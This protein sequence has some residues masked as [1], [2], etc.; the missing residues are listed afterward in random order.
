MA[1][2]FSR[3]MS[4]DDAVAKLTKLTELAEMEMKLDVAH[5]R[6]IADIR[7]QR[8]SLLLELANSQLAK[9]IKHD[10]EEEVIYTPAHALPGGC[11]VARARMHV[12]ARR[13][14]AMMSAAANLRALT[15]ALTH[16]VR[17]RARKKTSWSRAVHSTQTR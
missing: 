13:A 5:K 4:V 8:S 11:K 17:A 6:K 15:R 9:K 3:E 10:E 2:Y 16:R 1:F 7:S 14:R 12:R